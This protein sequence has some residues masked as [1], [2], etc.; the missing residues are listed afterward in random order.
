MRQNGSFIHSR[1]CAAACWQFEPVTQNSTG[2]GLARAATAI[3][4]NVDRAIAH[5]YVR[6]AIRSPEKVFTSPTLLCSMATLRS[7]ARS[8]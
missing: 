2:T 4:H 1:C 5:G 3:Y 8:R 6:R 7:I